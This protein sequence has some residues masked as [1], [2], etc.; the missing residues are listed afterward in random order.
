MRHALTCAMRRFVIAFP[1][2]SYSSK[3][4]ANLSLVSTMFKNYKMN[5]CI[6]T[7]SIFLSTCQLN[8]TIH[9]LYHCISMLYYILSI[10]ENHFR[11]PLSASIIMRVGVTSGSRPHIYNFFF[12]SSFNMLELLHHCTDRAE[13]WNTDNRPKSKRGSFLFFRFDLGIVGYGRIGGIGGI[14]KLL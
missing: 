9:I 6:E 3:L 7:N 12:L 4:S 5:K 1:V 2:A 13:I 10:S 14:R 8:Y 11:L